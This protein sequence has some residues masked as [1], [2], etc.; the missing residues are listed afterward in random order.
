MIIRVDFLSHLDCHR[1]LQNMRTYTRPEIQSSRMAPSEE[2][3]LHDISSIRS[4]V[5]HKQILCLQFGPRSTGQ[6]ATGHPL[7]LEILRNIKAIDV[8][9]KTMITS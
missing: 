8:L 4:T 5:Y 3:D 7:L 9:E 2:K 6:S 1:D